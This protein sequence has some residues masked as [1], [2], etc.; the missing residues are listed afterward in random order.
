MEALE[1]LAVSYERQ[2]GEIEASNQ[3]KATLQCEIDKLQVGM[4]LVYRYFCTGCLIF[5]IRYHIVCYLF[6]FSI[7]QFEVQERTQQ[8]LAIQEVSEM[9]QRTATDLVETLVEKIADI[10]EVFEENSPSKLPTVSLWPYSVNV[11]NSNE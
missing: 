10:S 8:F 11:C 6:P 2:D 4:Y 3:E 5:H 9:R 1:E 7:P